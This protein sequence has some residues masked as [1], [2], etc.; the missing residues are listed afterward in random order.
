MFKRGEIKT[1]L[2]CKKY[3]KAYCVWQKYC[4]I[5]SPIKEKERHREYGKEYYKEHKK[6]KKEY[7]KKGKKE[8]R[9]NLKIYYQNN[10]EKIKE[11]SKKYRKEHKEEMKERAKIYYC[12]NKGKSKCY[13]KKP[14]NKYR[15]YKYHAIKRNLSFD[16]SFEEFI[17][18]WKRDCYYCGDKIE[19]IGIDRVDNSQG[20]NY[21]NCVSCCG[22][23]NKMKWSWSKE[24]FIEHIKKIYQKQ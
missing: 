19:T 13:G 21:N 22:I 18:F 10:K 16:L 20:Y 14:E 15:A 23:C 5:C 24:K 4:F 8:I 3:F 12:K 11:R 6:E 1:C 17:N 2:N 9:K 7:A